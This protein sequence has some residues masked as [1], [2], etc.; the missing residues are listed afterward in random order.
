M[1]N[2]YYVLNKGIVEETIQSN[3]KVN[4]KLIDT[5]KNLCENQKEH[6]K[7]FT[8]N[9]FLVDED[10]II[11]FNQVICNDETMITFDYEG[12]SVDIRLSKIEEYIQER[13]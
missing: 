5:I 7:D 9:V 11:K 2:E 6:L 12:A 13:L 1:N 3:Y 4:N 8:I 10:L